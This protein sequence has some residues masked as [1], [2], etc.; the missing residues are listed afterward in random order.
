MT[1]H[2]IDTAAQELAVSRDT[3]QRAVKAG[4]LPVVRIGRLV[5]IEPADLDAF[6]QRN[7]HGGVETVAEQPV[8]GVRPVAMNPRARK[9]A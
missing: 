3:I 2:T 9:T 8:W 4:R 1:L 5:R 7:R 6:R